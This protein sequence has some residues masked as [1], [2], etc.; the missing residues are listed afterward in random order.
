MDVRPE[1]ACLEMEYVLGGSGTILLLHTA[2]CSPD[3]L[4]G[5]LLRSTTASLPMRRE[6]SL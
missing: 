2:Y 4:S 5:K 6:D 3:Y 1:L